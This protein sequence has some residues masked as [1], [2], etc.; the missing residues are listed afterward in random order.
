MTTHIM[1]LGGVG[2]TRDHDY[3]QFLIAVLLVFAMGMLVVWSYAEGLLVEAYNG[4]GPQYAIGFAIILAT[5]I[6]YGLSQIWQFSRALN[7]VKYAGLNADELKSLFGLDA[8]DRVDLEYLKEEV[9]DQLD[10]RMKHIAF[11]ATL[12]VILGLFGTVHGILL[13]LTPLQEIRSAEDVFSHL[14]DIS[15][16]LRLAFAT[17]LV[18]IPIGVAIETIHLCASSARTKL[19]NRIFRSLHERVNQ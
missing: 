14:G 6:G 5:G 3:R 18:G 9:D 7:A 12:S 10:G 15:G 8:F 16:S 2:M 1:K 11:F 19:K 17:T 4:I 13:A